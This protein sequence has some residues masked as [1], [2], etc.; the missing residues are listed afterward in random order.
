MANAFYTIGHSTHSIPDFVRMLTSA[1]VRQVVD[2]RTV[3]RS[4]TNSQF[5]RDVLPAS[6]AEFEIAYEHIAQDEVRGD[7]SSGISR[8]DEPEVAD[9]RE[10]PEP[11][12]N[13]NQHRVDRMAGNGDV[14]ADEIS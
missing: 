1:G 8:E 7:R 14:R 11:G 13:A 6:L 2:V 9:Q 4:R 12:R 10:D 5:N 3:P